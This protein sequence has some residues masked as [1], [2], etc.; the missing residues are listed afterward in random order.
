MIFIAFNVFV[1]IASRVSLEAKNHELSLTGLSHIS[2]QQP[3]RGR[4]KK[5]TVHLE[6][7]TLGWQSGSG[8]R[9]PA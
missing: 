2:F 1:S 7:S 8:R 4:R 9:A 6:K 5:G 3:K